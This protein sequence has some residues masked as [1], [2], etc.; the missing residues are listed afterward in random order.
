MFVSKSY[1]GRASDKFIVKDCGF[2]AYLKQG[3]AIMV[4]R[5]FTIAKE[6]FDR[7]VKLYISAFTKGGEQ[8]SAND[9]TSTRMIA[10]CR[11]HVERAIRRLKVFRI[12]AGTVPVASLEKFDEILVV[13][14][15]LVN[16]RPD[17]IKDKQVT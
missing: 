17:L 12:L 8:L 9:V 3:V 16:L 5:G 2:L 1:G 14:A 7:K 11:I 6:M 15:A 10:R 13:C 4:D